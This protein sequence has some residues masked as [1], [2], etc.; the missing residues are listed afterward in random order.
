MDIRSET[1]PLSTTSRRNRW[2]PLIDSK[3]RKFR[4]QN[5]PPL[6]LRQ[7]LRSTISVIPDGKQWKPTGV[8]H[9]PVVHEDPPP[10]PPNN[11]P[12]IV[13]KPRKSSQPA[14]YPPGPN[15]YKRPKTPSEE[16]K[17]QKP[18]E[19]T[20]GSRSKTNSNQRSKFT[21]ESSTPW[22]PSGNRYYEPVPYFD[23]PSLRW[24]PQQI[25]QSLSEFKST[26]KNSS[27]NPK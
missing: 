2:N 14:W 8:Y 27:R 25:K 13:V 16:N 1:A 21:R 4:V 22:H 20:N 17:I 11:L 10:K 26:T 6:S 7:S 15:K 9:V 23:A 24:S 12:E 5:T 19:D 18:E 3:K